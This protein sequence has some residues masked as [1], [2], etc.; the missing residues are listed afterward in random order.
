MTKGGIGFVLQANADFNKAN[1]ERL[2]RATN[3]PQTSHTVLNNPEYAAH[4][5]A[6]IAPK[7]HVYCRNYDQDGDENDWLQDP[8]AYFNRYGWQAQGG[9]GLQ[10]ANEPGFGKPILD[11]LILFMQE[12][13]ARN[14]P[15]S[16]GGFSVGTTPD[17]PNGWA[18]YDTFVQLLCSH[19]NLF[20]LDAHEYGLVVPTSGMVTADTKPGE[21][22]YFTHALFRADQWPMDFNRV[23]NAYH[24]GRIKHLFE[25]CRMKGYG[26]PT[27][28]IGEC[29]IDFVSD[30]QAINDWGK[31]LPHTNPNPVIQHVRGYKSMGKVWPEQV[32]PGQSIQQTN[33]AVLKWMRTVVYD[34]IGVRSMRVF[35]YG[36][37]GQ[38]PAPTDWQDFDWNTD[39]AMQDVFY[40][41]ATADDLPPVEPPTLPAFPQD[42]ATRRIPVQMTTTYTIAN[43]R[44][45]PTT[46]SEIV[47]RLE[48]NVMTFGWV[49][50]KADLR[51]DEQVI[52]TQS[53]M[54]G[55]WL[56]VRFRQNS[57]TLDGWVFA[58]LLTYMVVPNEP[59]DDTA[60]RNVLNM[61]ATVKTLL[62]DV[63]RLVEKI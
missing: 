7:S 22:L 3:T 29:P 43:V 15:I 44:A 28:D 16:I 25:Y 56:P 5:K 38:A 52:E 40:S 57:G 19:P 11:R 23:S 30:Q 2:A 60:R 9:L 53:G 55:V 34:S 6:N 12:A 58:P 51:P 49:I 63:E 31:A 41:W 32:A 18:Q 45:Q 50:P 4:L 59:D 27:V 8:A 54:T 39:K 35:T 26:K 36:N 47:G 46:N 62:M 13:V 21:V 1:F 42:F 10:V 61:L 14:I 24:I 37:S 33:M 20:T 48:R 17:N